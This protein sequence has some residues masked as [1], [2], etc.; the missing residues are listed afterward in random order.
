LT[1]V[2]LPAPAIRLLD[3]ASPNAIPDAMKTLG[4]TLNARTA[5]PEAVVIDSAEKTPT[6]H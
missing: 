4:L 5:P 1:G 2:S 3:T 6:E